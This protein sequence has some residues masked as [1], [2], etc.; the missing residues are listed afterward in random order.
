MLWIKA[1]T[2]RSLSAPDTGY[3][4]CAVDLGPRGIVVSVLHRVRDGPVPWEERCQIRIGGGTSFTCD[5]RNSH[6]DR[7]MISVRR[8]SYYPRF[9][10]EYNRLSF[11]YN[12]YSKGL[13]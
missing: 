9:V 6:S 10:I 4:G 8:M 12:Y 1:Y 5:N 11:L 7:R 13:Y 2:I 3:G